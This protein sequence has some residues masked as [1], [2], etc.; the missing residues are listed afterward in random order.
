MWQNVIFHEM[1]GGGKPKIAIVDGAA[2]GGGVEVAMA[3]AL[4][5]DSLVIAT[6][7]TSFTFPEI[8]LGF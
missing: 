1:T 8:R 7:R 5:P 4:D 3:F 6:E 2:F